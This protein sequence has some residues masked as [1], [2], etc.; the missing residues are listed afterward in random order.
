MH[1]L[2]LFFF[3]CALSLNSRSQKASL[4]TLHPNPSL[5]YSSLC[6]IIFYGVQ[7]FLELYYLTAYL[8]TVYLPHEVI[9]PVKAM[10]VCCPHELNSV[11]M[12]YVPHRNVFSK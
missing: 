5:S 2:Q 3:C 1:F 6:F 10:N 11:W 4:T 7:H 9:S 8:F 12:E